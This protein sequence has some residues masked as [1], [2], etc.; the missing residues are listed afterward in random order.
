MHVQHFHLVYFCTPGVNLDPVYVFNA[1]RTVQKIHPGANLPLLSRWSKLKLN[2]G[3]GFF[4]HPGVFCAYERKTLN[5]YAFS[6]CL[7]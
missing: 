6:V 3:H 1:M 2:P 4:L 7:I 5:R